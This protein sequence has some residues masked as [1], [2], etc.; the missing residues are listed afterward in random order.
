MFKHTILIYISKDL[1]D[2]RLGLSHF[3]KIEK[4]TLRIIYSFNYNKVKQE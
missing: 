4:Y 2:N 1:F 3:K